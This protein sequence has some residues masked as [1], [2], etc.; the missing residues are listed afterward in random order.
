MVTLQDPI[1]VE[2]PARQVIENTMSVVTSMVESV[3]VM[4]PDGT[5]GPMRYPP[6]AL[7]EI[8]VNAVIH[9]DY[10]VS[11]DILVRVFDNR[12]DVRSPGLLPGHMTIARLLTDRFARNPTIV[13]LL[14]KY[15]NPPN[16]DIGEGL[17][18]VVA[19]MAEA[20]LQRPKF[21]VQDNAFVVILGHQ[22]LARPQEIVLQY[23]ES[24]DEITN[25]IG[26]SLTGIMSEN[27]MKDVFISLKKAGKLEP[28]PGKAGSRSA[29]QLM[30][31]PAEPPT[32]PV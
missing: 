18:T 5:M 15:P 7:K 24:N 20:K 17:N 11:D 12:V 13:R 25:S 28:V 8:I 2:G 4:Q 32:K 26:R 9:R 31:L 30:T 1:S 29:W 14:N 19:K 10:N 3:S 23:L 27:S 16:K 21:E 22:P 6:D